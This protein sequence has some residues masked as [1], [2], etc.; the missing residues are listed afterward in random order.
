MA[1]KSDSLGNDP[2]DEEDMILLEAT[3]SDC[4]DE[5]I[6]TTNNALSERDETVTEL[7][8][9]LKKVIHINSDICSLSGEVGL[10]YDDCVQPNP[11]DISLDTE[12]LHSLLQFVILQSMLATEK[13]YVHHGS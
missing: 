5:V 4:D 9:S 8:I 6:V 12:I 7:H 1:N 2:V 11:L 13:T 3:S 10:P